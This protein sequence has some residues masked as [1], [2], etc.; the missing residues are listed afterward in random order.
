MKRHQSISRDIIFSNPT[1]TRSMLLR[2][3][4]LFWLLL[5][6]L[7]AQAATDYV[8]SSTGPLLPVGCSINLASTNSYT[9]GVL[10]LAVGDT[11]E[12]G[13]TPITITF[14]GA[15][16]TAES[17]LINISGA[18]SDLNIITN[19]V[20]TLG[21]NTILNA[22]VTG[23]TAINIGIGSTI[24]GNLTASSTTGVVTL[25]VNAAVGGFIHT[26]AGA[27]TVGNSST[28]GGDVRTVAG[29][30]ILLT[31]INVGGD[32]STGAGAITIGDGSSTCGSVISTGAGIVTI[33]TNI[34]VGGDV[35]TVAGAIKIGAGSTVGGDVNP[36]GAG[37]VT[38]TNVLV[39]GK[40]ETG[41][42]AIA[43]TDTRVYGTVAATGGGKV[44][45]TNSTPEDTTLI[46]PTASACSIT[47]VFH[48]IQIKHDG[49]GL[50]CAAEEVTFNACADAT[51]STLYND[52]I[53]VQLSI[54]SIPDQT[55]T[56]YG[57]STVVNFSFQNA[58]TAT[59]SVDN[60]YECKNGNLVSCD[61]AFAEAGF[62]L[63]LDNHQSCTTPNLT[64][65]AVKLSDSGLDCAPAYTG[66]QSVNFIF[67][68]TSPISGTEV[69]SLAG[70]VMKAATV[71]QSRTIEFDG[72][73]TADLSFNYQDAGQ[74]RIDVSDGAAAGLTAG[75][76]T[77]VVSPAK[78]IVASPDTNA[79]CASGDATCS[80][81]KAAGAKFNLNITASCNNDTV[82]K[83][84]EMNNIPLTVTTVAPN[85]GN[86]VSLGVTSINVL[87]ADNGI[88]KEINQTVS[89]VG[90]FTITATPPVNGYFGETIPAAV[91]TNI[92]RFIPDHFE[93]STVFDGS[94]ISVCDITSPSSETAFAYTGQVGSIDGT[95]G[96]LQ[97][98]NFLQPE[99]L[100]TAKTSICPNDICTTAQN[101]TVDFIKLSPADVKYII[102]TKDADPNKTG[103]LGDPIKL[104]ANMTDGTLPEEANGAITYAFNLDDNFVYLHEQNAEIAPFLSRIELGINAVIDSDGVVA[105]DSDNDTD[106][107]RLWVLKPEGKDIRFGRASLKNSFGPETSPIRQFL[108]VEY[109]N[110]TN[111]VL[112]NM[113]TCTPYH[114]NNISFSL[115]KN[116]VGLDLIDI[117]SISGTFVESDDLPN[118]ATR[119]I[120]LPALAAGNR[121]MVEI[122]YTIYPWLQYDWN[123]NGVEVKVFDENPS[124]IATF[125]LYRGNDRII[126]IREVYN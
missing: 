61:M 63:N 91:S 5:V 7:P 34:Q 30:V 73:G 26:D 93:L 89:E 51:C 42:G 20:L 86:P 68:Y 104:L 117:P 110:G 4:T 35:R 38:L 43:L 71:T 118:G 97:Y 41:A 83:N 107:N 46:V 82:T 45:L 126:Y 2:L 124:A 21:A 24:G 55:V 114:S 15:F 109:F 101:Y 1:A 3:I 31:D 11:I 13:S 59:L 106:N 67:N 92:G 122:F 8:F 25:A 123:W 96:V 52:A 14:T 80:A 66:N 119:Q 28:V 105:I 72:T 65:K 40:V 78:L 10:T 56:I 44:T 88:H 12:V 98:K 75:S 6:G 32:I 47:S 60:T 23:T 85:V 29:V 54:N 121:G 39:G 37:V 36:T 79:D 77:A 49:E 81:F 18:I 120:F 70:T 16:T 64:I 125:G 84:F 94:I 108:S 69:P 99:L 19:G 53:D 103:A 62:L 100:I 74:V 90:V 115:L 111:F 22:N 57:G 112:A 95:K 48:H 27:V 17:N 58:G 9:C 87:K 102:P 76:V 116:E 113:D 50:T 33:T